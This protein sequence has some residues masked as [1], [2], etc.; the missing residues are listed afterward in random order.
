MAKKP[1]ASSLLDEIATLPDGESGR[2]TWYER[3]E[4]D[5]PEFYTQVVQAI[6]DH[7]GKGREESA[8]RRAAHELISQKLP[9]ETK[10]AEWLADKIKIRW[11]SVKPNTVGD[12]IRL[13]KNA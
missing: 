4:K 9:T 3:L 5:Q 2:R 1:A 12:L 6:D 11:E 13:R 10:L 7:L 8:E